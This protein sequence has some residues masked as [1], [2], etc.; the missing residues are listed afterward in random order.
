MGR[1]EALPRLTRFFR[2][3]WVPF[4]SIEER[5]A[6]YE[7]LQGYPPDVRAWLVMR[8]LRSRDHEIRAVCERLRSAG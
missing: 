2:D 5:R 7:S 3:R 8:G 6:A 1:P 4:R